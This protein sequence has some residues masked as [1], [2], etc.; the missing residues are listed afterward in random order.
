[1]LEGIARELDTIDY[2]HLAPDQHLTAVDGKHR[3][4]IG[5]MIV[6]CGRLSPLYAMNVM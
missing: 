2:E 4:K 5:T 1:V 3:T 6:K